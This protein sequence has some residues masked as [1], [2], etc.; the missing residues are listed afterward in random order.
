ME[1]NH[2]LWRQSQP[3]LSQFMVPLVEVLG[4]SERRVAAT[5]LWRGSCC[6]V[7]G[8]PL[9]RCRK[10]WVWIPKACSNLSATAPGEKNNSGRPFAGR[11]FRVWSR[12]KV[13]GWMKRAGSS[14]EIIRWECPISIAE[15]RANKPTVKSAW[16]WWPA[17]GWW[18]RRWGAGCIGRRNG[19]RRCPPM[20]AVLKAIRPWLVRSTGFCC[21]GG[22]KFEGVRD[23][24][25]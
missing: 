1:W 15:R 3:Y 24:T 22:N 21:C 11:S 10:D 23:D 8:S 6:P 25:T 2:R 17:M 16:S 4:R 13:G 18:P 20:S 14:K 7:S 9:S 5:R 12:L 19:R